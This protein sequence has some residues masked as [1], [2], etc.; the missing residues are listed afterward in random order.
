MNVISERRASQ[1]EIKK[2]DRQGVLVVKTESL[3]GVPSGA[4]RSQPST[5][6]INYNKCVVLVYDTRGG[7]YFTVGY[8]KLEMNIAAL[9]Q[10]AFIYDDAGRSILSPEC[11]PTC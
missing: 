3:Y 9:C 7:V 4:F 5:A 11:A 1:R 2:K 8:S 10:H 6:Y